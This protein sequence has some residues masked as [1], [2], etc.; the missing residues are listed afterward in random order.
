MEVI[1]GRGAGGLPAVVIGRIDADGG[2]GNGAGEADKAA[3]TCAGRGPGAAVAADEIDA[4]QRVG[5][6]DTVRRRA[7]RARPPT[8][9]TRVPGSGTVFC[10]AIRRA[11]GVSPATGPDRVQLAPSSSDASRPRAVK[12]DDVSM[13]V[14]AVGDLQ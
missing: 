13:D 8:I 14:L 9:R 10:V 4:A 6:A 12:P 11:A 5:A 1:E 2:D 7:N 3:A